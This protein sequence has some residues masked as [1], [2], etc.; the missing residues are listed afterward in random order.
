MA[1]NKFDKMHKQMMDYILSGQ[2]HSTLIGMTITMN[3]SDSAN[4]LRDVESFVEYVTRL[5]KN[6][7]EFAKSSRKDNVKAL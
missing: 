4:D 3:H 1:V 7:E 2:M 6:S 5:I